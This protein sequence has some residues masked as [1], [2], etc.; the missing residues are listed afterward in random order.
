M[1]DIN[2]KNNKG[3]TIKSNLQKHKLPVVNHWH[4]DDMTI[5]DKAYFKIVPDI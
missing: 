2:L 1:H 5:F 3:D 4:D